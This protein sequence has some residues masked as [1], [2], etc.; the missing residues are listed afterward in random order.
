MQPEVTAKQAKRKAP[1]KPRYDGK[2]LSLEKF[3]DFKAEDGFKYEWNNG[4]LE[5]RE[6]NDKTIGILPC[7]ET[8]RRICKDKHGDRQNRTF[9]V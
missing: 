3:M 9:D 6:K 4:F 7:R 8:A 2:K 1:V 5:A